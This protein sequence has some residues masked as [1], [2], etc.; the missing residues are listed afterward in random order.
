MRVFVRGLRIDAEI[1]LYPHERERRQPLLVDITIELAPIPV[2]RFRDTVDY[3]WLAGH[4]R[5]L[6]A[7][8]HVD[9]VETYAQALAAA[10]LG[11]ERVRSVSVR[12]E[13]PDAI[14][15][16]A[17]AGVEVTLSRLAD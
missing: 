1:G 9:L 17:A 14:A 12:V 3:D 2:R 7:R 13:K 5:T 8:G 15:D 11:D 6:A 16:A 4:A 10:C